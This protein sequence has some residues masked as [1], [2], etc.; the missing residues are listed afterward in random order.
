MTLLATDLFAQEEVT[1]REIHY[2]TNDGTELYLD[3]YTTA[4]RTT[5]S[6]CMI[7]AFGGGFARGERRH[8]YYDLYFDRL[9]RAGVVVL[10][11]DYRLGLKDLNSSTGI[12]IR[13][14]V[15]AMKR[16]IDIAVE[17]MLSATRYAID[18]AESLGIDPTKIM[19]SG[20]SAG[21]ITALQTE[22]SR[23]NRSEAA[24][25][26]PEDF[27]YAAVVSC[28]GAIFSISGRPEWEQ[29]PA[30]MLLFH[31]TSDRNVPY[32]KAS[33][34]GIGFYGSKYIAAQLDKMGSPYHFCSVQ[35]ADHS[36]AV[37]PLIDQIDLILQFIDDYVIDGRVLCT[38]TEVV[39]PELERAQTRFSVKEYLEANYSR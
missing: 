28:A 5:P 20:S 22:W 36:I 23:C 19:I 21:A 1:R 29:Q 33:I 26:L 10:S 31:G 39:M 32:H 38:T 4:E 37:L 30:P 24:L 12:D 25:I 35:Y 7:F 34:M 2:A 18:N 6:P 9:A 11:I 13:A 16:S 3:C 17:D 27:R 8:E 14:M 15:A